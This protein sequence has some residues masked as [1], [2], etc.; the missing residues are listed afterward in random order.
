MA[1]LLGRYGFE[2]IG[3]DAISGAV[4]MAIRSLQARALETQS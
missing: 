2:S 1:G 4:T 3:L